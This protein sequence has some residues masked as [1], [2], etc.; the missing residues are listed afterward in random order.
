MLWGC[1]QDNKIVRLSLQ[2]LVTKLR[3]HP[4]IGTIEFTIS[5]DHFQDQL[6]ITMRV[7][8]TSLW[9]KV[10]QEEERHILLAFNRIGGRP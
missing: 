9:C 4:P 1:L 6:Q 3:L 8:G 7:C 5:L 10:N 2:S